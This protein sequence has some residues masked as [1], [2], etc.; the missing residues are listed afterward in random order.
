MSLSTVLRTIV[1]LVITSTSLTTESELEISLTTR[2]K[3]H[4][5]L[6]MSMLKIT[7]SPNLGHL[8]GGFRNK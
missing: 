3:C 4:K 6:G 7:T 5:T 1:F 8:E 2:P